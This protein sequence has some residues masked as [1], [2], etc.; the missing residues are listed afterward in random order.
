MADLSR[1]WKDV[2]GRLGVQP[3]QFATLLTVMVVAVGGLGIKMVAGGPRKASAS[4]ST[5]AKPASTSGSAAK[6]GA[7]ESQSV[8]K[9]E[10]GTKGRAKT[11]QTATRRV[12]EVVLDRDPARDPFR[13]WGLPEAT[14]PVAMAVAKPSGDAV[15]GY[16]PG[17]VL[18]AVVPGEMAVFGDQTV[19]V[20]DAVALPDGTFAR[21]SGIRA[22]TVTVDWN[23]RALDVTF[24]SA[25]QPK[26]PAPGG[27]R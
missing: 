22:R 6:K 16:L 4:T 11:S 27:F 2:C 13:P 26:N 23:G 15:P 7:S 8:S 19:R 20:G 25:P 9:S 12:I 5:R 24:G 18:K 3:K 21:V 14:E 10:T 1:S 17:M